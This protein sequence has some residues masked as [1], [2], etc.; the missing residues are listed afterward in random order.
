MYISSFF[1]TTPSSLYSAAGSL[2]S[3]HTNCSVA[4]L[5]TA[6][7]GLDGTVL[8][9]AVVA[10]KVSATRKSKVQVR[11]DDSDG[12]RGV[13]ICRRGDMDAVVVLKP[14]VAFVAVQPGEGLYERVGRILGAAAVDLRLRHPASV[15]CTQPRC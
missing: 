12:V 8:L 1:G 15:S 4:P 3:G 2:Q 11:L 6:C 10:E 5:K 7:F 13:A 9:E 14:A